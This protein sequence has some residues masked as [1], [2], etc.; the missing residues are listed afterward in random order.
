MKA[1]AIDLET[2]DTLM[3]AQQDVILLDV[4]RRAD[5]EKSPATIP[6][7]RWRDPDQID[8]WSGELSAGQPAVVYCVKGGPVSQAAV[9]RLRREGCDARYLVGGLKAWTEGGRPVE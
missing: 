5:Y 7:A 8:R 3:T 4:R 9:E 2:L 6:G 1:N